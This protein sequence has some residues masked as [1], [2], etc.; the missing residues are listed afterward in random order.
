MSSYKY[1]IL[2]GWMISLPPGEKLYLHTRSALETTIRT[3]EA[4]RTLGGKRSVYGK[5]PE[6]PVGPRVP[7]IV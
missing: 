5:P 7:R 3:M 1:L 2:I 6:T 4:F